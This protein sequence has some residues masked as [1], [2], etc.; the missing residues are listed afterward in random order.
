MKTKYFLYLS[1]LY[2]TYGFVLPTNSKYI[3]NSHKK[4]N[5]H[6]EL[7][8]KNKDDN[9][10]ENKFDIIEGIGGFMGYPKERKWKG[11]RIACYS[12]FAGSILRSAVVDLGNY[13]DKKMDN[14]ALGQF[15]NV[16]V[17]VEPKSSESTFFG[18]QKIRNTGN[19]KVLDEPYLCE[20]VKFI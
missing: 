19:I 13:I 9:E 14:D 4:S 17:V 12:I 7:N 20:N 16:A 2:A 1:L 8:S 3:I 6:I 15:S 11:F 18:S 5:L 10:E